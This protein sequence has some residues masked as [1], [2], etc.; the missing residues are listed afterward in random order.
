MNQSQLDR[1]V[2]RATGEN[3]H[4]I[5]Q[6]GFSIAD[7]ESVHYDP[8]P[9]RKGP[10]VVDWDELDARRRAAVTAHCPT[11][12]RAVRLYI[13]SAGHVCAGSRDPHADVT[14]NGKILLR[15]IAVFSLP[16]PTAWLSV[17]IVH[18]KL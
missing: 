9:S 8:E 17:G 4:T 16:M 3:I 1:A 14:G 15:G 7:P 10:Q 6:I 2:A 13:M 11:R 12:L 18:R 5:G